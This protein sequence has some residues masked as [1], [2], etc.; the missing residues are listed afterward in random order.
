[1]IEVAHL[2]VGL[3]LGLLLGFVAYY[4][5]TVKQRRRDQEIFLSVF[6]NAFQVGMT[7]FVLHEGAR[8]VA[9]AIRVAAPRF[10]APQ[11]RD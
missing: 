8:R 5:W 4:L 10:A 11:R 6:N 3:I 7:A 2:I 9:D 1:M